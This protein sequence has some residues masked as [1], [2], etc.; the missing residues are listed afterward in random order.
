MRVLFS[1]SD[2]YVQPIVT[3]LIQLPSLCQEMGKHYEVTE[4]VVFARI[5][6]DVIFGQ[7][8]GVFTQLLGRLTVLTSS[9][10]ETRQ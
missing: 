3:C 7:R 5:S 10:S 2:L 8:T 1:A 4:S 9:M 6:S